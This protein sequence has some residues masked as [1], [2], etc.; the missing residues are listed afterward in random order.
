MGEGLKPNS[1]T[2]PNKG[3]SLRKFHP[4]WT[5]LLSERLKYPE[6][7]VFIITFWGLY[8]PCNSL[9]NPKNTVGMHP[10]NEDAALSPHAS[11]LNPM[12]TLTKNF[13]IKFYSLYIN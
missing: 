10:S 2:C 6:V 4:K 12:E 11:Q 1:V 8:C 7:F 13:V 3:G 9:K 5:S